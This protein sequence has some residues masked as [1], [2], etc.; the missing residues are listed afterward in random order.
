MLLSAAFL[1][2]GCS[3]DRLLD[4]GD[5]SEPGC[6]G[7][8]PALTIGSGEY[9]WVDLSAQSPV[10]MVHGP[11]GGW[12]M[13]GSA[14]IDNTE[15]I[16]RIRFSIVVKDSGAVIAD[17]TY[18]VQM[19]RDQDC[20]G[21]YPG[22]YG[23]LDVSALAEGEADTPPELLSNAPVIM[24]MTATDLEQRSATATLEVIAVPDPVDVAEK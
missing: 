23:Y 22:M 7:D 11:Q 13:L 8:A 3:G 9:E 5:T 4:S 14:R 16:V 15:P 20:S 18:T 24:E 6:F 10:T 21:Y 12:H 2:I 19:I 17:N 1:L